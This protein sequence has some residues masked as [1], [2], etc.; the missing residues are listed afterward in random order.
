MTKEK[1]AKK[2]HKTGTYTVTE[3]GTLLEGIND[4]IKRIAEG[5]TGLDQRMEKLEAFYYKKEGCGEGYGYQPIDNAGI[6]DAKK[7]SRP[8][9]DERRNLQSETGNDRKN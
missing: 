2:N 7:L 3:V 4:A 6:G 9:K 1:P 5:H 8:G